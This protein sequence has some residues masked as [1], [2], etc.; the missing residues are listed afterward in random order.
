VKYALIEGTRSEAKPK[1]RGVCPNCEREVVAKCGEVRIWHWAH[2]GKLEC[3]HWWEPETEWHRS[4]KAVFP[5]EW[6]EVVHVSD[7]GE[8]HIADVKNGAGVVIELQH[9]PIAAEER[10]SRETFYKSMI[11]VVDGMRYKRD[12]TAFRTAI[13]HGSIISDSPMYIRP[14]TENA[15]IFRR[16][17]PLQCAVFLDFGDENFTIEGFSLPASVLWML[18]LDRATGRLVIC[19]VTRESFVQFCLTGSEMQQ[20]VVMRVQQP[21]ARYRLP[22]RGRYHI[23]RGRL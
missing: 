19:A 11:W 1:L 2:L 6:Q 20:L 21:T 18:Q 3:D 17:T 14:H 12:L 8:R 7:T 4:W 15:A 13:V 10:I 23:R 5:S 9:S 22:L 16:W